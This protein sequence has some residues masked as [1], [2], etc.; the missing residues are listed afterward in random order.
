MR[1]RPAAEGTGDGTKA[2]TRPS[3]ATD[4][5]APVADGVTTAPAD[6]T[7]DPSPG[8]VA[9]V[10]GWV[11]ANR[12]TLA[13][14]V[15][16]VL[17]T[18]FVVRVVGSGFAAGYPPF[19]PDSS[20]FAAVARRGPFTGR[21]WFDERPIGFPLLFWAVGR[22]V[23]FVVLAQIA[24]HVAAF[25]AVVAVAVRTLRSVIAQLV[26][27]VFTVALAVQPR[28]ALW[29]T[30][31][32]SES[33]AIST[34]VAAVAAWWWFATT[35]TRRR[36]ILATAVT[37]AFVLVRD[38]NAVVVALT[39]LPALAATAFA[40]R[41]ER[42]RLART[43]LA[44][45]VGGVLVCGYVTVSQD[46]ADRN[47]YPVLNNVGQR[48]LPDADMAAWFAARGM[49][50]DDALRS[51][52][53]DSAFD[54]G[55]A[56]LTDP[57][58][59]DLRDWASG[60]GQRWQLVSYVRHAPFWAG[61]LGDRLD[62]LLGYGYDDYDGF[63]VGARTG[64]PGLDGPRSSLQLAIWLAVAGAG[65]VLASSR[66]RLRGRTVVVAVA[67]AGCLLD[68][69]VSFVGDSVEVQRHLVPALV[70]MAVVL[71]LGVGLGIEALAT[72]RATTGERDG[73][74]PE[75]E[76]VG[77]VTVDGRSLG[78]TAVAL[79]TTALA[80]TIVLAAFF[81]NE[82]R[83]QDY[84]PQFMKVLVDRVGALGVSYYEGALH[85]K[86]PFEPFVY[87]AAA[88]LTS[89]DGFWLAISGFVLVAALLCAV[90]VAT[91][92]RVAGASRLVAGAV[93]G[94]LFV[95]L[96]LSR[97]DY[98]GVLYSRNMTIAILA[99]AWTVAVAPWPWA[100]APR[101][102]VVA[103]AAIGVLLGLC[104]QTLVTSVFAGAVVATVAL[105]RV[106]R[107]HRPEWRRAGVVL[108]GC[109]A[110]TVLAPFAWYALRGRF[111]EFWGGWWTYGSYQS[112][113][114]GRSLFA[115]F[116]LAWD[117]AYAYYRTWP[118]S[119]LAL[120]GAAGLAALRWPQLPASQRAI[121]LGIGAWVL[122]AW[123]ELAL[124]QRYSSHYFSVLALPTWLAAATA[125]ADALAL[126]PPRRARP[127][128]RAAL[129][130]LVAVA[131]LFSSTEVELR[132]GVATAS[133]FRGVDDLAATRRAN[134][135]GAVRTVR[136]TIDLVSRAG[137]PLLAWT[138]RPW[139]Y[140]QWDRTAATRY[141]W[142]SFL[143]GQIYLGASGP[144]FVPPHTAEWFADDLERTDPQVFVE[145]IE[146]PV[147]PDSLVGEVVAADFV[148]VYEGP[149]ER[150]HLRRDAA[151]A[152]LEPAADGAVWEAETA[153][154]GWT[155]GGGGA[156]A[157]AQEADQVLLDGSCRRLDGVLAGD[158]G[159]ETRFVVDDASGQ[160][161]TGERQYLSTAA[162]EA[163]S[164]TDSVELERSTWEPSAGP[165]PFSIVVG[166]D[167]V[168]LLV[169][170]EVRAAVRTWGDA[171]VAVR[172][173]ASLDELTTA[174]LDLGTA[175]RG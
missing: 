116:G 2:P 165:V 60:A 151:E 128:L 150:V 19:F 71:V 170:G 146:H 83:S 1:V 171:R 88:L 174:P 39:V 92:G 94:G 149:T 73:A 30:H 27:V 135:S 132:D 64:S 105:V 110:L 126:A 24:L 12:A 96:V 34:G 45:F 72:R 76:P 91:T 21:F 158:P 9:R 40:W 51:H 155:L 119:A 160:A 46:V 31:V 145:E 123:I 32:L 22:S 164:S 54:E 108:A 113:G 140:L 129:P 63:A 168:A 18:V 13:L 130:A 90:A 53:G 58:L 57:A 26:V 133:G 35:P 65:L 10:T 143:L 122:A 74:V 159:V 55:S 163:W 175:C 136:A 36:A 56:M 41:T 42:P 43:L 138:E 11:G 148:P 81:G 103:V 84:D 15:A 114:L 98:A 167:S 67:L 38:S 162:G 44:A 80:T 95:H 118:L 109:A 69:Y 106:R 112:A 137:D 115:Q 157:V 101:R 153:A 139:T 70:R 127:A 68:V 6:A 8:P 79:A 16:A 166:A 121:R 48:I 61:L 131:V 102:R 33:L 20:S 117:Q 147:P 161:T 134:E 3:D 93:G 7:V 49:P 86:G 144:Q 28:V 4:A 111:T 104:V 23:R 5:D 173:P 154:P 169:D 82:L 75:P 66:P 124:A 99:T 152:L 59:D 141:V 17:V 156:T 89:D 14:H 100:G 172:P 52:T 120:V 85:N 125:A 87:R 107:D 62:E 50:L 29:T 78:V 97:A 142:G 77:P 25:G 47:I 37:L